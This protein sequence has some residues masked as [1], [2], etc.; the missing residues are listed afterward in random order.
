MSTLL[1]GT[2]AG[3]GTYLVFTATAFGWRGLRPTPPPAHPRWRT[4]LDDWAVQAGLGGVGPAR[5]AAGL[6]AAAILGATAA[7]ILV[8]PGVVAAALGVATAGA[9]LGALRAHHH[10]ARTDALDAW[11]RLLEEVRVGVSASGRSIPHALFAAG[12]RAPAPMRP[13]FD[14]AH[15]T[16]AISTDLDAAFGV[17]KAQLA[18]PTADV[19]CET[20]LVAHLVGGSDVDARLAALAEDRRIDLQ[21]RKDARARQAGARFARRFV[22][23][24]PAGMAV[25]GLGIGDGRAAYQQ[26]AGQVLLAVGT[27]LVAGCWAWAGRIMRLPEDERVLR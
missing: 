12:A 9:A 4:A 14:A 10:R 13:A 2:A 8:G 11:P 3:Y 23:L 16:W 19:V 24:V 6:V 20:L 15:R 27:A 22:L 26:P 5:L 25:A 18:D 7:S 1:V 21:G 17:L